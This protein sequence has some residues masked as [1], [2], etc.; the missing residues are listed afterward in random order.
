MIT[1]K[2]HI[3]KLL[4]RIFNQLVQQK[5]AK[6]CFLPFSYNLISKPIS[7]FI[8]YIIQAVTVQTAIVLIFPF[9]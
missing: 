3:V 1:D 9:D 5:E 2:L 6:M 4:L 7:L 8:L